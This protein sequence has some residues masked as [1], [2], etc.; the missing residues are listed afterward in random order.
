MLA[1]S[2]R[3]YRLGLALLLVGGV[4]VF[5]A[6][7]IGTGRQERSS[8]PEARVIDAARQQAGLAELPE[9]VPSDSDSP[10]ALVDEIHEEESPAGS[11]AAGRVVRVRSRH[12][13]GLPFVEVRRG[14][15]AWR[16]VEAPEGRVPRSSVEPWT[17]A[18]APGHVAALVPLDAEE[19]LL[20]ADAL[21]V[22]EGDGIAQ[23]IGV[24][25]TSWGMETALLEELSACCVFG[26]AGPNRWAVAIDVL[27]YRRSFPSEIELTL[28]L[29]TRERLRVQYFAEP[30]RH[31]IH[32]LDLGSLVVMRQELPLEIQVQGGAGGS[33]GE[34]EVEV[35]SVPLP[36]ED[37]V[38]F[39]EETPWGLLQVYGADSTLRETRQVSRGQKVLLDDLPLDLRYGATALDSTTGAYGRVYFE[40]DGTPRVLELQ[41]GA[42]VVGRLTTPAGRELP[43]DTVLSW[44]YRLES[45]QP[46]ERPNF[47]GSPGSRRLE[48]GD[49]KFALVCP[50]SVP[51][52]EAFVWPM[53][54][55]LELVVEAPGFA[56]VDRLLYVG[57]GGTIDAGELLLL[58]R[59]GEFVL[60]PGHDLLPEE[61]RWHQVCPGPPYADLAFIVQ[62]LAIHPD[63]SL[64]AFLV[65]ADEGAPSFP[66]PPPQSLIVSRLA[67]GAAFQLRADGSFERV[68]WRTYELQVTCTLPPESEEVLL[69]NWS[70]KGCTH[71]IRKIDASWRGEPHAIRFEAPRKDAELWWSQGSEGQTV[72]LPLGEDALEV[73]IP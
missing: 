6:L 47:W 45:D 58:P 48:V 3:R 14:E 55:W 42:R 30:G 18:R 2:A 69:L 35:W 8:A 64:E 56:P 38:T 19:V 40:H 68:P 43:R 57:R 62:D 37:R 22:L 59:A 39:E 27:E 61:V 66:S 26:A 72:R 67:E 32:P 51:K 17:A 54:P 25:A 50:Q 15:E 41:P 23:W 73:S 12:G 28:E 7:W 53:P 71:P 52:P 16:R 46:R 33:L 63:G 44:G 9:A 5:A 70:W 34:V 4:G 60:A 24:S 1:S 11:T 29:T 65:A 13:L 49:G 21:L 20:D 31:I 36:H 10:R